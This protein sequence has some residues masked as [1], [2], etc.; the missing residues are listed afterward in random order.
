MSHNDV[1]EHTMYMIVHTHAYTRT[2]THAHTH[3]YTHTP[4]HTHTHTH[5]QKHTHTH[6]PHTDSRISILHN[7][8]TSRL[9]HTLFQCTPVHGSTAVDSRT[10]GLGLGLALY[11]PN[12]SYSPYLDTI[13]QPPLFYSQG[14][15]PHAVISFT[16]GSC[17]SS[18]LHFR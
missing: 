7:G 13:N 4:T 6:T 12:V 10:D 5:T 1:I 3:T 14:L 2:H 18:G 8:A 11:K 17:L 9:G 16:S 15:S